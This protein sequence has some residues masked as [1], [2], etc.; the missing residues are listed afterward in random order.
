MKLSAVYGANGA[1]KSNLITAILYLK[2]IVTSGIVPPGLPFDY[3]RLDK[4]AEKH[5]QALGA[6]F[7]ADGKT[8]FY[9]IETFNGRVV[10]EELFQTK[11]GKSEDLLIFSR[12]TDS[13]EKTHVSFFSGF[14]DNS[15]NRTLKAVI[16][17][18]LSRADKP[19]FKLLSELGNEDLA[20]IQSAFNWF[21]NSLRIIIPSAK[22]A[23]LSYRMEKDPLLHSFANDLMKSFKTGISEVKPEKKTLEEFAGNNAELIEKVTSSIRESQKRVVPVYSNLG[24]EAVAYMEGNKIFVTRLSFIHKSTDNKPV[25]FYLDN[26]SAGTIRLLDYIPAFWEIIH[27]NVTYIV[28]EIERSLHPLIIKELV[29]KFSTDYNTKG[30]LIFTTHESN[31]LDQD[32]FRQDEIW[33]AEK[34]P[35]GCTDLYP[36]SDFKEH[37]TKDIEKGYLNG[38]YGGV[39]FL[40]NLQDLHW[41]NHEVV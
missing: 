2:E 34:D 33:F 20:P 30:Q 16:E 13:N 14:E 35:K 11:A 1:G 37:H 9:G 21:K 19:V 28:D 5:P 31:L 7:L 24:E 26:E 15:E 23:R 18:N 8:W 39:P 41:E 40:G 29:Q 36:L 12:E 10:I 4:K 25:T 38:R 17:K 32:I 27:H 6:E 22:P 3:F